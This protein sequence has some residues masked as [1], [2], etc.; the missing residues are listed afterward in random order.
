MTML[1]LGTIAKF[2]RAVRR[3]LTTTFLKDVSRH[4]AATATTAPP[5]HHHRTAQ[6]CPLCCSAAFTA[7]R[8]MSCCCCC[9]CACMRCL[10]SVLFEGGVDTVLRLVPRD[11]Q[12]RAA[13]ARAIRT[14]EARVH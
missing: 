7:D 12:E 11:G 8:V 1:Q 5:A 9:M 4:H 2:V 13:V 3:P 6:H 14:E 10:W